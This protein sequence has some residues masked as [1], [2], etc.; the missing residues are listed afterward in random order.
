MV[1]SFYK[2]LQ[3]AQFFFPRKLQFLKDA[4]FKMS[5]PLTFIHPK[6]QSCSTVKI[7]HS[8]SKISQEGNGEDSLIQA[9]KGRSRR[10]LRHH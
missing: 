8:T 9:I 3:D 5:C 7:P 6:F 1:F 10:R 2:S 4:L